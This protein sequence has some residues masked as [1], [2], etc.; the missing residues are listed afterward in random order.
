MNQ[1]Y[2]NNNNQSLLNTNTRTPSHTHTLTHSRTPTRTDPNHPCN[3]NVIE[4]CANLS[5]PFDWNKRAAFF[6]QFWRRNLLT[7]IS[8]FFNGFTKDL[9]RNFHEEILFVMFLTSLLITYVYA[10]AV[11]GLK[12]EPEVWAWFYELCTNR[13]S[14]IKLGPIF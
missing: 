10:R 8:Y 5:V 11:V 6:W 9:N 1:C 13:K 3:D 4:M 14:L 7:Y 2:N 12:P